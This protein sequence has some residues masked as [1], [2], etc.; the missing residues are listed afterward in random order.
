VLDPGSS[1]WN[2]RETWWDCPVVFLVACLNGDRLPGAHPALPLTPS[3]LAADALAVVA[4][5]ADALHVHPRG[6]DGAESLH[7]DGIGAA[8]R[9]IRTAVPGAEVGVT[10]GAWIE[11]DPEHRV[12]LVAGWAAL[13]ATARPD[14]ASVNLSEPGAADVAAAL[15]AAGIGIEPG[16]WYRSDLDVLRGPEFAW[17]PDGTATGMP[18]GGCHRLLIEPR[19]VDPD[20]AAATG[21]SLLAALDSG[22]D[23]GIPRLLHGEGPPA[24]PVLH[25][26]ADLGCQVRI[27]LED[28]LAGL[29]GAPAGGNAALVRAVRPSVARI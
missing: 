16:V 22:Y 19:D 9:A 11:P 26:A 14:S 6:P 10:T 21:R 5:G 29:D 25:L 27:G 8:V 17:Q 28:T 18:G 20:A 13:D 24:W 1:T 15:R 2:P 12:A 3:E 7:G 23:P 4:A